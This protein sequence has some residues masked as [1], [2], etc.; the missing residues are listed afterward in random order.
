MLAV[1][2]GSVKSQTDDDYIHILHRDDKTKTGYGGLLANRSFMK[3]K[4][5][6]AR[7]VM[8]LDDDDMLVDPDFVKD[9]KSVLKNDTEIVF[10]KGSVHRHGVLPGPENWGKAPILAGISSFCLAIR[11]DIWM[12]YIHN[13][14]WAWCGD[15]HFFD[16]CYKNTKNHVWWDRLVAKTQKGPGLW[17]A[18][19]EHA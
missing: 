17:K 10:F 4:S 15:F 7:Y 6:D 12:K 16:A 13:F 19:S 14:S 8:I 11:T 1:C 2:V 9:F 5:I 18:E 3:I